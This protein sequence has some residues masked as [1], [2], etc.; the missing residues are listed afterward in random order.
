MEYSVI[1]PHGITPGL[2][3][4]RGSAGR[5]RVSGRSS[6]KS[7]S[8]LHSLPTLSTPPSP[9]LPPHSSLLAI[10]SLLPLSRTLALSSDL[11]DGNIQSSL[12][13]F[14]TS[15]ALPSSR[16]GPIYR[17]HNDSA[18]QFQHPT[19]SLSLSLRSRSIPLRNNRR[20]ITSPGPPTP[21]SS[22]HLFIP[23]LNAS[24]CKLRTAFPQ[25]EP[26]HCFA[27]S[28]HGTFCFHVIP[29]RL[30][31]QRQADF[32]LRSSL[33]RSPLFPPLCSLPSTPHTWFHG[34]FATRFIG[35]QNISS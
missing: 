9:L 35:W 4:D 6:S 14:W 18:R 3:S 29:A 8:S 17:A 25:R 22:A 13:V 11:S 10:R 34:R 20:P 27:K 33:V 23:H 2:A 7:A 26:G 15:H 28:D 31:N 19:R 12:P 16:F 21:R 5:D 24:T 1:G 32:L 30:F